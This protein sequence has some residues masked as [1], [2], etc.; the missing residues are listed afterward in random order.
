MPD[1]NNTPAPAPAADNG[2]HPVTPAPLPDPVEALKNEVEREKARAATAL[3]EKDAAEVN[4][5]NEKV[6]RINAEKR[7]KALVG[8]GE[9]ADA[10]PPAGPI[11]SGNEDALEQMKAEKGIANL[12]FLTPEYQELLKGNQVLRDVLT[13]NPLSLIREYIDA[14][15][16]VDQVRKKLDAYRAAP[17]TPPAGAQV[18]PPTPGAVPP[19]GGSIPMKGTITP[20]QAAAMSPADWAKLPVETRTKIMQGEF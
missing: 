13:S 3:K 16:A 8:Q 2:G 15:D 7:L 6:A 5:R 10:T 12:L 19:V 4:A 9:G 1:E 17:A 18:E 20:Q 11:N 14:E